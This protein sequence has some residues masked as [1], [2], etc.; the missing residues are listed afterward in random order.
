MTPKEIADINHDDKV[1]LRMMRPGKKYFFKSSYA[2]MN[3]LKQRGL[4][5]SGFYRTRLWHR[6]TDLGLAVRRELGGKNENG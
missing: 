5:D 3:R 1:Y 2:T 6:I 4:V